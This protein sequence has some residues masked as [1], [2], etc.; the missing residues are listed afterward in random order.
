MQR[1]SLSQVICVSPSEPPSAIAAMV[2]RFRISEGNIGLMQALKRFEPEK[3]FRFATYA[4]WWI[5]AA[6][7]DYILRSWS[8]VKIGTTT[9]QR[10][11]FFKLR[12]A[13][14]KIS[15]FESGDLRPDQVALIAKSLD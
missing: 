10:K 3:G 12:S 1:T 8:L 15:A 9:N 4:V 14:R 13:K 2:C 11:L 7:Q 5:R 6:I